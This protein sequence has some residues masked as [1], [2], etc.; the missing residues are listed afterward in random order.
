MYLLLYLIIYTYTSVLYAHLAFDPS[1]LI[2]IYQ[3][4]RE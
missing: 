3:R 1:S 2:I 4:F